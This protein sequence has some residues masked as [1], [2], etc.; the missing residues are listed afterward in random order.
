MHSDSAFV[1]CVCVYDMRMFIM[2]M[3]DRFSLNIIPI[4]LNEG[5][6]VDGC[7]VFSQIRV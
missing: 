4:L 1:V 5:Q 3:S 6:Q 7:E 2:W